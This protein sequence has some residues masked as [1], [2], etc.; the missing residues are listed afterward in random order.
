MYSHVITFGKS[1]W[2]GWSRPD[3]TLVDLRLF[4]RYV[5]GAEPS[6]ERI[7]DPERLREAGVPENIVLQAAD[8]QP[9]GFILIPKEATP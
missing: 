4:P 5:K 9:Q 8:S 1:H 7:Y 6:Q 3:G 2:P